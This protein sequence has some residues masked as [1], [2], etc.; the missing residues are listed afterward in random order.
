M[1]TTAKK[2]YGSF[3]MSGDWDVQSKRLQKMYSELTD[4]DLKFESGH[5]VDLVAR[6]ESRLKLGRAEVMSI[7][8]EAQQS[9]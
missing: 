8:R 5:L 7:M 3:E 9:I 1:S 6:I 4:T 2:S